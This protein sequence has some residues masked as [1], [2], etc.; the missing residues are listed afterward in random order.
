[1]WKELVSAYR[2]AYRK[3][4]AS[5]SHSPFIDYCSGRLDVAYVDVCVG[6]KSHLAGFARGGMPDGTSIDSHKPASME[7]PGSKRRRIHAPP[8]AHEKTDTDELK[9]A[10]KAVTSFFTR[11]DES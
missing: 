2:A 11:K 3:S 8:K 1:M 5:G 4:T 6:V 7:V 10:L 9:D